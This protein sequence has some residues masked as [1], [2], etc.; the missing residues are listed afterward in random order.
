MSAPG[1]AKYSPEDVETLVMKAQKEGMSTAKIGQ[2]LRDVY[3]IPS[4]KL[5][6][7]K[8]VTKILKEKGVTF[9]IP[10]DLLCLMKRAVT[11]RKHLDAHKDDLHSKKGLDQTEMKIWRLLKYYKKTGVL[12]AEWKYTPDT[13][14]LIVSGG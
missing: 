7:N 2:F 6:T 9:E 8:R 4:V 13:A 10:E 11:L 14:A 5:M 3:G 12:P 1:W